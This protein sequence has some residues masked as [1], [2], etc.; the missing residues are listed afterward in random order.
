M[1]GNSYDYIV[2]GSG[3][4]GAV[5]ALRL[6]EKGYRVLVI[7]KGKKFEPA[8]FPKNN[9]SLRK[10]LW[11]PKLRL[12]GFFKMTFLNHVTVLSGV[13]VGGG[14]LTYA[15]TLHTPKST[16][17]KSGSWAGLKDLET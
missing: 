9:W 3:F 16:F 15:N 12:N 6:S 2:I 5:S 13:G 7:E 8:D 10:W 11:E 4:G 14:S 1:N 17:F